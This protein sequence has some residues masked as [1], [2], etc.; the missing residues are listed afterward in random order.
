[1]I[2]LGTASTVDGTHTIG[3]QQWRKG[4]TSTDAASV[5]TGIVEIWRQRWHVPSNVAHL[6]GHRSREIVVKQ[7]CHVQL[8]KISK[9]GRNGALQEVIVQLQEL[10]FRQ[11]SNIGGNGLC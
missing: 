3:T 1:L 5:G 7:F 6:C 4:D 8:L 9:F 11:Q 10:Q 2:T